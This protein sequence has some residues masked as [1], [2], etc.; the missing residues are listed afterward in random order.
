MAEGQDPARVPGLLPLE[1]RGDGPA[2]PPVPD[3]LPWD[4]D[5]LSGYDHEFVPN[6]SAH[7]GPERFGGFDNP[8]LGRRLSDWR[9]GAILLFGYKWR[10]H[11]GAI[12][13]ARRRRVPILFRGDSHLIGRP[14]PRLA[15]RILLRLLFGQF[16]ACLC[17]GKANREYFKAFGVPDRKLVFA[18]HSVNRELFEPSD[19]ATV[20]AGRS[21]PRSSSGLRRRPGS[22]SSPGN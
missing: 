9:P 22:S 19:P 20:R 17:V 14:A 13:W 8:A 18:P 12:A 15:A 16:A 2:G 6:R 7:P 11:V 1:L 4:V 3:R 10:S 5:L 21:P